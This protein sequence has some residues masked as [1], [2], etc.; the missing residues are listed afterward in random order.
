MSP[1]TLLLDLDDTLYETAGPEAAAR[2]Q[3]FPRLAIEL[4]RD[5]DEI[6]R[7]WADARRAVHQ[8]LPNAGSGHSR[9]LYVGELLHAAG[10]PDLLKRTRDFADMY[11]GTYLD[12]M[13][14]RPG[15]RALLERFKSDGG[16]LAIVTD[17]VLDVQLRKLEALGAFALVDAVATSEEAGADKPDPTVLRLALE[18]LG[19]GEGPAD[20]LVL[21]DRDDKDG[22]AAR[23]MGLRFLNVL[24]GTDAIARA[25]SRPG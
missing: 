17:L 3:L 25:L 12:A 8:R 6:A 19:A 16:R 5:V 7:R 20:V 9:L 21:G 2:A 24:E 14:W 23:A 11:W 18:R 13:C 4:G 15:L 10:R 1:R 22:A